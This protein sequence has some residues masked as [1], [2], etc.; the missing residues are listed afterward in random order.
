MSY[1]SEIGEFGFIEKIKTL[2]K[3]SSPLLL[4]GIGDD[5]AVLEGRAGWHTLVTCDAQVEDVHFKA[6]LFPPFSLGKR[7]LAVNV[8]D[9]A[10]MGGL[11]RFALLSFAL[12][13]DLE[14]RWLSEV[15][16]GIREEA[17]LFGVEVV[18]GNLSRI[19]NSLVFDITLI[20]EVEDQYPLLLRGNSR[21]GDLILV[22]GYLGEAAC[23][24]KIVL[25]G[26]QEEMVRFERLC[27]RCLVPL[28]RLEEGRIIVESGYPCALID[29]SDGL[30]QDLSHILEASGVGAMIYLE[31]LPLSADLQSFARE[32]KIDPF[33]PVLSG[34]EDFELLFTAPPKLA[35]ELQREIK[36]QTGTPVWVIG[37]I[38]KERG[39]RVY[40]EGRE[41]SID[42][43]GWNHFGRGA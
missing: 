4:Q 30:L 33:L 36:R 28:P 41:I 31:N 27:S 19:A 8:S 20:G 29:V 23:G 32:K 21:V 18:G 42:S 16:L 2:F 3:A 13:L 26:N 6:G 34:G 12:R 11:P 10:A 25:E 5:C 7:I 40:R 37:E 22:T 39:L 24:L 9:I 35:E 38:I 43:K 14:E 1:L 15:L 17:E